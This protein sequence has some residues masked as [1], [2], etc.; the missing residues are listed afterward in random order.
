MNYIYLFTLIFIQFAARASY[1]TM[2]HCD[3][4]TP[5]KLIEIYK[6]RVNVP[7]PNGEPEE[8]S[9]WSKSEIENFEKYGT[10][11]EVSRILVAVNK[12]VPLKFGKYDQVSFE[13]P[14]GIENLRPLKGSA[15][16][17][18]TLQ[19]DKYKTMQLSF[20][21]PRNASLRAKVLKAIYWA[22]SY[23]EPVVNI[24]PELETRA[25]K[26]YQKGGRC[27]NSPNKWYRK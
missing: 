25:A 27:D 16:S 22:H 3:S 13:M 9:T 12:L 5:F 11:P 24:A 26:E 19:A 4:I 17:S 21:V 1:A 23:E 2:K 7:V 20:S 8:K 18:V 6:F 14:Q 15:G 10:A